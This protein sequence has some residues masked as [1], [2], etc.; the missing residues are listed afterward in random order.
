ME[1]HAS[2]RELDRKH[3]LDGDGH[4]GHRRE[5]GQAL[6][7]PAPEAH[8]P[9]VGGMDDDEGRA[10][11]L[12][13]L[14]RAI[15]LAHRIGAEDPPGQEQKRSVHHF[16]RQPELVEYRLQEVRFLRE[17]VL[18]D[19]DLHPAVAGVGD[20]FEALLDLVTEEGR[21]GKQ[22]RGRFVHVANT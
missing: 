10:Q 8:L 14:H 17:R 11:V 16:D 1:R 19:H 13:Q 5:L 7:N 2:T 22:Q 18:V 21:G 12:R 15:Y 4:A 20:A 6:F 3:V 9:L